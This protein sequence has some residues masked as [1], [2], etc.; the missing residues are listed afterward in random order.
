MICGVVTTRDV[1]LHAPTI[2]QLFGVGVLL[3]CVAAIV[4][5]RQTTFLELALMHGRD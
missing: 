3:R 1:L 5:H 4:T 2:V